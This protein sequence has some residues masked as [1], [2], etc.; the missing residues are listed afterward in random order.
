MID[1]N[2]FSIGVSRVVLGFGAGSCRPRATSLGI[3]VHWPAI[4]SE[5]SRSILNVLQPLTFFNR[6]RMADIVGS[7]GAAALLRLILTAPRPAGLDA[8]R[9]HLIGHSFGCKVVCSAL[10]ALATTGMLDGLTINAALIAVAFDNDALESG[11]E[12]GDVFARIPGVRIL[13]T[14]SE[15]DVAL[16]DAY[17]A[18]GVF[19]LRGGSKPALGFAGP[20]AA[21]PGAGAATQVSID[22]RFSLARA[23]ALD[24]RLIIADLTPLHRAD[25]YEVSDPLSG[26]HSDIFHQEIYQLI[27]GF[28]FP[29]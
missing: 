12:Y 6:A 13:A 7:S 19:N 29:A 9:I 16:K 8:P 3:G 23:P 1:Y 15:L 25:D 10:Q 27:G 24:G 26:H 4:V 17:P 28:M 21:T 2:N 20:T 18:A 11:G 5:D 22:L 14:R